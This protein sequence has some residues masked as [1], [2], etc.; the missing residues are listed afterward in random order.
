MGYIFENRGKLKGKMVL[1]QNPPRQKP[2][3]EKP[4]RQNPHFTLAPQQNP[5]WA[6]YTPV[7]T[8]K[9]KILRNKFFPV[10]IILNNIKM[11]NYP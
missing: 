6:K 4:Y 11:I 1:R 7:K 9:E 10:I 8:S 3:R 5:H 2:Y